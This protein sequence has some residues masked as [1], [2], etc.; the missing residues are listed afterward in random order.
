MNWSTKG[1]S[2]TS[3]TSGLLMMKLRSN[4]SPLSFLISRFL[5]SKSPNARVT[6]S[7]PSTLPNTIYPPSFLILSYSSYRATLWSWDRSI[8]DPFLQRIA[9]ASPTL[10][11]NRRFPIIRQ[12]LA[13][14]PQT[15]DFSGKDSLNFRSTNS[16][17]FTKHFSII[18]LKPSSVKSWMLESN[19]FLRYMWKVSVRNWAHSAPPWPSNTA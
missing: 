2:V 10:A 1:S 8:A 7:L 4:F 5:H 16:E 12:M 11:Q 18:S 3:L 19:Y 17:V 13:V 14:A 6:A 15:F 9:L